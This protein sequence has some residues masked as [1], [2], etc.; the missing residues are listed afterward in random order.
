[1][2]KEIFEQINKI[3]RLLNKGSLQ[4]DYNVPKIG[5]I[6]NEITWSNYQNLAFTLKN[7]SY[8]TVYN[9]IN[10]NRDYNFK[11]F[12][13]AIVQMKYLFNK[14]N[15]VKHILSYY[16]NPNVEGFKDNIENY[17]EDY[18][19]N[20][21]FSDIIDKKIIV[22]P[23]RFDYS[24]VWKDCE[25]P[26]VHATFGN[27]TDCRIP[28]SSPISPNR[29]ILFILRSFYFEKFKNVFNEDIIKELN[30]KKEEIC[31]KNKNMSKEEK[32]FSFIKLENQ[33][34]N[35]I[36]KCDLKFNRQNFISS[37][38]QEMLH[39]NFL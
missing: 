25:H 2:K 26:K 21:L 3:T 5:K 19:G 7:E 13:Q 30:I 36:F 33:L 8:E 31:L 24:E 38:E 6:E 12:D 17:E 1:M 20:K 35:Q 23:I 10:I 15:L 34:L 11:M 37:N 29:F 39:F 27:F 14:N 22:F 28:V 16:P 32:E 4:I 18:F 9:E